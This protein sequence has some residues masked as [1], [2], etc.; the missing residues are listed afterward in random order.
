MCVENEYFRG[1]SIPL[2]DRHESHITSVFDQRNVS[3]H[4]GYEHLVVHFEPFLLTLVI[5]LK[6]TLF[7]SYC[8]PGISLL[9]LHYENLHS[10]VIAVHLAR[11]EWARTC[12]RDLYE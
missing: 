4:G 6:Q 11:R 12:L 5:L 8:S 2:D 7:N 3:L 9:L 10:S 1:R